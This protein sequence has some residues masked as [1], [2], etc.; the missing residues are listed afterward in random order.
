MSICRWRLGSWLLPPCRSA[1]VLPSAVYRT[2]H[3]VTDASVVM[4]F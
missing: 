3:G 4:L 2:L 1:L